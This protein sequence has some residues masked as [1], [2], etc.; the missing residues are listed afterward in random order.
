MYFIDEKSI[1]IFVKK[2]GKYTIKLENNF[3]F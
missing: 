1:E 3:E 2:I